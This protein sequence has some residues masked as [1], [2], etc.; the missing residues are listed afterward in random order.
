MTGPNQNY[1][2]SGDISE[3]SG[4]FI[5]E[6]TDTNTGKTT[7]LTF[8]GDATDVN[9]AIS[10]TNKSTLHVVAGETGLTSTK[11]ITF[12]KDITNV[13]S[14]AANDNVNATLEGTA[15]T[16][17]LTLNAGATATLS[18][19]GTVALG[20]TTAPGRLSFEVLDKNAPAVATLAEDET[21]ETPT[22]AATGSIHNGGTAAV[23]FSNTEAGSADTTYNNIKIK[24]NSTSDFALL[25]TLNNSAVENNNTGTI[26]VNAPGADGSIAGLYA[27]KGG[28]I[29]ST[30][31]IQEAVSV[32]VLSV[33]QGTAVSVV[34]PDSAA[35]TLET[36][37]VMTVVN[38]DAASSAASLTAN[39]VVSDG[40]TLTLPTA[41]DLGGH[42]LTF[43]GNIANLNTTDTGALKTLLFSNADSVTFGN[44]VYAVTN[45]AITLNGNLVADQNNGVLLN[46][47]VVGLGGNILLEVVND[48]TS[49]LINVTYS[50]PE[51]ATATLGLL[52]L[53]GLCLRRRRK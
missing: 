44:D 51:P 50:V 13:T 40:A 27:N 11:D 34:G 12:H 4:Q 46:G 6:T 9:I 19:D 15:T 39:L 26:T 10:L 16:G 24:A 25:G 21:A 45:G 43:S 52:A 35:G 14:L 22:H 20:T 32:G 41:L 33:A 28:I 38:A 7:F 53:A 42:T 3:W 37:N 18:G 23:S 29:V 31:E 5:K 47:S 17:T 48:G 8:Q 2:F 36:G 49:G 30:A 1:I